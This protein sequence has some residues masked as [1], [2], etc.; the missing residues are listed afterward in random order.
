MKEFSHEVNIS[1]EIKSRIPGYVLVE[2][3]KDD[4]G[5]TASV[6]KEGIRRFFGGFGNNAHIYDLGRFQFA[7]LTPD[8][9]HK[10]DCISFVR[11]GGD[12]AF[13]EGSFLDFEM[14]ARCKAEQKI[15]SETLASEV[16]QYAKAAE[17]DKLKELNG[18]YSGFVYLADKDELILITDQYGA[19]RVYVY[20]HD[21]TF[22]VSNNV[23]ALAT[24]PYLQVSVDEES[25]ANILQL[26]YPVYRGTEFAEI[27]LVL[28]SDIYIRKNGSVS[29]KKYYQKVNRT[30]N[31]SDRQYIDDLTRTINKFFN[32]FDNYNA[33]TVGIYLSKGKDCRL[34]LPFLERNKIPYQPFVFKDGTGVF[35][36]PYV[37]KISKLLDKDLHVLEDYTV[38]RKLAFLSAMSTT[39]TLSWFALGSVAQK[40]TSTALMGIFGDISSGKMPSF[41]VAGIKTRQ[42]VAESFFKMVCKGVTEEIVEQSL[43]YF[44]KFNTRA[45]YMRLFE[46][47]PKAQILFDNEVYHDVDHRS[48]RNALPIL[49]RASHYITPVTP[50]TDRN[51]ALAYHSLPESLLKSQKAHTKIAAL[52][53]KSSSV[54]TT[55]FPI[56]LSLESKIRPA[57]MWVIRL[58]NKLNNRFLKWQGKKFNPYVAVDDFTPRS[59]YFKGVFG[60][61]IPVKV[62]HKRL[63]TR[64]YNVDDYLH[65]VFNDDILPLCKK[66]HIV[67]NELKSE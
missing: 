51:I 58:N 41:R 20:N 27:I 60:N 43:P 8:E 38:D 3:A 52:D 19:N 15:I 49:L 12:A 39:P 2:T 33:D 54:Q 55:A 34:F 37:S 22:A 63:L 1:P 40:Y 4:A 53:K 32:D 30:R 31:K 62:G 56:S 35:D 36:Y 23:F 13:I 65:L 9:S 14:L 48:F 25:V 45:A 28:P 64:M 17:Y 42:D 16:L 57:M 11:E 61:N 7:L 6:I 18:R 10:L 46:D 67:V 21:G 66:P 47:Y 59:D 50:Y 29:Y 26:E 5:K 44:H 24:N